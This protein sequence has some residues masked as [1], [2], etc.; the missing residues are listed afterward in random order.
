LIVFDDFGWICN[1]PQMV[2][3]LEFMGARGYSVLELPTGRG[4]VVKR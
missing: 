4:L 3:E 2:A 1:R